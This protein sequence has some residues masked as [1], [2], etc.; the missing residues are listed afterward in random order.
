MTVLKKLNIKILL[1]EENLE[2]FKLKCHS[3]AMIWYQNHKNVIYN[4]GYTEIAQ[5]NKEY[6]RLYIQKDLRPNAIKGP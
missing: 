1:H 5:S 2:N 4:N 3:T 6:L